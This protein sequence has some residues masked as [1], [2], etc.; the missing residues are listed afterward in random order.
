MKNK[1]ILFLILIFITIRLI[2][3]IKYNIF[4]EPVIANNNSKFT[5]HQN[6]TRNKL[7]DYEKFLASLSKEQPESVI[8][9]KEAYFKYFPMSDKVEVRNLA[10]KAYLKFYNDIVN[11]L[12]SPSHTYIYQDD[13]PGQEAN[14]KNIKKRIKRLKECHL[15]IDSEEG[16]YFPEAD[17]GYLSYT[18]GKY[19]SKGWQ[20][21]LRYSIKESNEGF[22]HDAGIAIPWD[23]MRERII[24]L[25]AFLDKYPN[26]ENK[27]EVQNEIKEYL[28]FYLRGFKYS[29]IMYDYDYDGNGPLKADAKKSYEKFI[30]INKNSKYYPIILEYYE[31][32]KKHKFIVKYA[33]IDNYIDKKGLDIYVKHIN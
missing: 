27:N 13:I 6:T 5:Y 14:D 12:Y 31:L 8:K 25:E 15:K 24:F 9:G 20:E 19:L 23:K 21:Y 29:S 3:S 17:Y 18:F 2:A 32:L 16:T 7:S 30:S 4:I 33:E 28:Y 22:M 10:F 26:F 1:S 11:A